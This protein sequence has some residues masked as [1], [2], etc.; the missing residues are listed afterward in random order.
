M[1]LI[2]LM[3]LSAND[4]ELSAELLNINAFRFLT[5]YFKQNHVHIVAQLATTLDISRGK[6]APNQ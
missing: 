2:A 4:I 6:K 1:I 5:D 3:V